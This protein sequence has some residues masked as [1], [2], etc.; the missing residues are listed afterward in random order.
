ML[1]AEET[2]QLDACKKKEAI[3]GS[4]KEQEIISCGVGKSFQSFSEEVK[5]SSLLFSV[6]SGLELTQV[7]EA[8]G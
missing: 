7:M 4:L 6:L 2:T 8:T 1:G 3:E 5:R